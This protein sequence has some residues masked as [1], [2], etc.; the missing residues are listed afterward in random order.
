MHCLIDQTSIL[1]IL[2]L[3]IVQNV[4]EQ[5]IYDSVQ[6]VLTQD[7]RAITLQLQNAPNLVWKSPYAMD[8]SKDL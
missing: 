1:L 5:G 3:Q 4:M 7:L 2:Q 6:E 8:L